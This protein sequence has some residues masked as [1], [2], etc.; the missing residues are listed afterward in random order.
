MSTFGSEIER[1]VTVLKDR[2]KADG[3]IGHKFSPRYIAIKLLEGDSDTED[4]VRKSIHG[5]RLIELRNQLVVGL[6]DKF[7]DD[8]PAEIAA[9]NTDI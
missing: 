6:K 7:S 3:E 2:I 5:D 1:A 4:I 9:E 8:V